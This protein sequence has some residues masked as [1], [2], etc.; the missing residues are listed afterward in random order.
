MEEKII[1]TIFCA[2]QQSE[3]PHQ[4]GATQTGEITATCQCVVGKTDKDEDILCG[5][6]LKFP[7]GVDKKTFDKAVAEQKKANEG[8]VSIESIN[9]TLRELADDPVEESVVTT[10][11]TE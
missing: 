7:A 2:E 6:V 11:V 9:K 10:P 8:Q 5:R 4:L 3:Q 1:K